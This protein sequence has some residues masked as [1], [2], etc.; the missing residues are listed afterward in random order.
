MWQVFR[1]DLPRIWAWLKRAANQFV[2]WL[3]TTTSVGG[4]RR[5]VLT[6]L[7]A[8]YIWARVAFETHPIEFSDNLLNDLLV[9]PFLSLFAADIVRHVVVIALVIWLAL[10]VAARYLDDVFEI[11]DVSIAE[12][13]ILQAVFAS[14]SSTLDIEDGQVSREDLDSPAYR[15]GGPGQV[16]VHLGN[17]ALFEKASGAPRVIGPEDG[18][19][20]LDRFERMRAAIDLRDQALEVSKIG[21]RTRDGIKVTAQGVKMLYSI[22]RGKE[23]QPPLE[24][25]HPYVEGAIEKLVYE[26]AVFKPFDGTAGKGSDSSNALNVSL[27]MSSIVQGAL[28]EFFAETYLSAFLTNVGE[29]ENEELAQ[30]QLEI[31]QATAELSRTVSPEGG[32]SGTSSRLED[33]LRKIFFTRD[34][35]SQLILDRVNEKAIPRGSQLHWIDIGTWDFPE[36]AKVIREQH[37]EAW[38]ISVENQAKGHPSVMEDVR[39]QSQDSEMVRLFREVPLNAYYERLALKETEPEKLLRE[40]ALTYR[41]KIRE[42]WGLYAHPHD[43]P[44]DEVD[45]V[46]RHLGW[47]TAHKVSEPEKAA[48]AD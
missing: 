25:P 28:G 46:T 24:H 47:I 13:Y 34:K 31:T 43:P 8:G 17:A 1:Q 33:E 32:S 39:R 12:E 26:Q 30:E 19:Q 42:A 18:P 36:E 3:F 6:I 41:E 22:A 21:G 16:H 23:K 48:E 7:V 38:N 37:L 35:L 10:Q 29:P 9:Y 4:A 27:N 2:N 40:L 14:G 15:I 45:M 44:P 11:N 5:R 20:P